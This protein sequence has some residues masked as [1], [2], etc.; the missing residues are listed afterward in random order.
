MFYCKSIPETGLLSGSTNYNTMNKWIH[1]KQMAGA[2]LY[3]EHAEL[4]LKL[5]FPQGIGAFFVPWAI[6]DKLDG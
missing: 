2:S 5:L 6:P 1:N 4:I 3:Y